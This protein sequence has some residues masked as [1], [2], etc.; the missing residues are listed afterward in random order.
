MF[1]IHELNL[2]KILSL[3]LFWIGNCNASGQGPQLSSID[4]QYNIRHGL[5]TGEDIQ[6]DHKRVGFLT[7]VNVAFEVADVL[8]G[9]YTAKTAREIQF[10]I[11]KIGKLNF[12]FGLR[13]DILFNS[14]PAQLD[15]VINYLKTAYEIF[16]GR[17]ILLWDHT[18]HNPSIKLEEG[19]KNDIHWNELGIG[20][21]GNGMMLGRKGEGITF[22]AGSAWI[23]SINWKAFLSKIWMRTEN[24]YDWIL[25]IGIRDDLFRAGRHVFYTLTDLD[26]IYD[27]RGISF[28]SNIEVGDRYHFSEHSYLIAFL[29][30]K[31]F[32]DWYDLDYEE[33]RFSAGLA[34]EMGLRGKSPPDHSDMKERNMSWEP[35]LSVTGGYSD[36]LGDNR[37]GHSSDLSIDLNMLK[38]K[39]DILFSFETY[40]GIITIPGELNPYWIKYEIGPSLKIDLDKGYLNMLYSYSSLYSVESDQSL[41]DYHKFSLQITKNM[42][43]HWDIN[44]GFGAYLSTSNFEYNG[45]VF[46]DL[47]FRLSPKG[48]SPYVNCAFNYLE[49]RADLPG[50]G[51]ETG[52]EIPGEKGTCVVYWRQQEDMDIFRYEEGKRTFLGIRCGF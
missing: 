28:N 40:A 38:L 32:N 50:Y 17:I 41:K 14:P 35:A 10:D 5:E 23:N 49:G 46:G 13:E 18:C 27:N 2:L 16:N 34:F 47:T 4:E 21:E 24:D 29:N 31:H 8:K 37:Y 45:E 19:N 39:S 33:D 7:D 30:Y 3:I 11:I 25:K 15:H 20:Y 51:I 26:T 12:H 42:R 36:I 9:D 44:A 43:T 48:I 6:D 1:K 22:S 52:L